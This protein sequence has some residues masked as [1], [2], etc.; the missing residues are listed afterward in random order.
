MPSHIDRHVGYPYKGTQP[1][2]KGKPMAKRKPTITVEDFNDNW[3]DAYAKLLRNRKF[4]QAI[5]SE[6]VEDSMEAIWLVDKLMRGVLKEDKYEAVM[7]A[8][9][10]D[11]LEAWEYLSGKFPTLLDSQSKD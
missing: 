7:A 10:D 5:H 1:D 6:G 2:T 3:A 8:F 4:Q 9:D 11:V